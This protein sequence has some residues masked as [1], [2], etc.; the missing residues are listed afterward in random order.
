[1]LLELLAGAADAEL[2]KAVV[3]KHLKP[4]GSREQRAAAPR[5]SHPRHPAVPSAGTGMAVSQLQQDQDQVLPGSPGEG[6]CSY[7]EMSRM[8]MEVW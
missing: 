8:P 6:S 2:L 7:P 4:V 3:L 1:M 5:Q